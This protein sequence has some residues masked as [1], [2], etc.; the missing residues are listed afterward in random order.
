MNARPTLLAVCR[1][2]YT[3]ELDQRSIWNPINPENSKI[4]KDLLTHHP[5]FDAIV[6]QKILINH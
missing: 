3:L 1:N 6:G 4:L 5:T 2:T